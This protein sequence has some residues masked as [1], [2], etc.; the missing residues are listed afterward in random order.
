MNEIAGLNEVNVPNINNL[1]IQIT[2]HICV[3]NTP[4][5][6]EEEALCLGPS[7]TLCLLLGYLSFRTFSSAA[8][9]VR[10]NPSL[11]VLS[12]GFIRFNYST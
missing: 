11:F 3:G 4:F 12:V 8:L 9:Q 1:Q 2:L 5:A 6:L 7:V 10:P